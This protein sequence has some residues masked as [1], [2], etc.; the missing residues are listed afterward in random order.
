MLLAVTAVGA[1]PVPIPAN[2]GGVAGYVAETPALP[3]DRLLR[4]DGS[5][6]LQSGYRGT[7]SIDGWRMAPGPD[8]APRFEKAITEDISRLPDAIDP[9]AAVESSDA[10]WDDR[11]ILQGMNNRVLALAMD[12]SGNLYAGG[13][14]TTA[15]GISASYIAK[16]NGRVWSALGSGMNFWVS[17]LAM[18]GSGNLYAGGGFTTAGGISASYIAKWN[19]TVWSALG[20]GMNAWVYAL[21]MDG[22][23]NLYAGGGFTT[24]GGISANYIAKW[25]GTVWSALGSGM[26]GNVSALAMD[27]SGNLYAGG[28]FTTAGGISANYIAKWNGTVWSALGSGMNG[29]VSALAMDGSGNLYAGGYFTTA[30]GISASYIAKWNGTVWSAL[31]SG[32]NNLGYV[33][34]LAMDGS[35]NLYAG[36]GFTT[37][38]GI[39]ARYIAKWNGTV[40]SALGPGMNTWVQALVT[41]GSG[42]LYA[43]GLFQAAGGISASYIAK[44]NRTVWSA[45]GSGMNNRVL[46]LAMDGSGNLYAGGGF[47]TAGGISASYIAKW[48]G[49]VWSALGSGMNAWVY[50]LAMDGSGNL[51][52][53]G[54]FT[55]AGGISASYIAKWNGTVWSAL[56][57]GMND[58]VGALAMDGSGNLYAGGGFS[59]AGGISAHCVAKWNGTVWSALGLGMW[60]PVGALAMDGSGNLYAGGGFTTAGGISARCIAKWNGTVWSA[61]GSGMNNSVSSLAMDGSNLYAGGDFTTAGGIS[62]SYIAK[63]NG[64]VWS[65]LGSGMNN[66]VGALAMD[67]G[68]NLYAGGNFTTAGGIL[69]SYVAKWNGTVWSALGSGMNDSVSSLA[70]DGSGNLYTGGYFTTAGAKASVH[71]AIWHAEIPPEAPLT[72]TSPANA[73][74]VSTNNVPFS[75]SN[76]VADYY[77]IWVD[78]E[79]SFSSPELQPAFLAPNGLDSLRTNSFDLSGSSLGAG[80]TY[81]WKVKAYSGTSSVE[82]AVWS[83]TYEPPVLT[84]PTWAPL[85]R[86]YK[87]ADTDHFYTTNEG[88]LN[89]AE[90]SLFR[91]ERVEGFVSTQRFGHADM[92]EL[93]RF[94]DEGRR[95]H[96]YTLEHAPPASSS[97]VDS[98][99]AAGHLYEG[100][101]GFVYRTP[102]PGLVPLYHVSKVDLSDHLYTISEVEVAQIPV[103]WPGQFAPEV[104]IGWVSPTGDT[105]WIPGNVWAGMVGDGISLGTGNF[106]HYTKTSFSIPTVGLPLEFEHVYNSRAVH[107]ASQTMPLGPGWSNNY[108]VYVTTVPD[109]YLVSWP[110][111]SLHRYSQATGKCLEDTFGVYD[112]M[113]VFGGGHFEIKK[114]NQIVYAFHKPDGTTTG[115]PSVLTSIRDRNQ[116]TITLAY[117]PSGLRRLS[118]VTD[119]AG[120]QL[121]F[122]YRADWGFEN[123]IREVRDVAGNRTASFAYED[124]NGNLTSFTDCA[125]QVTRYFYDEGDTLQGQNH[126]LTQIRLP[127]G[128]VIDNAYEGR[129]VKTQSGGVGS[130]SINYGVQQAT[131]QM[132]ATEQ[133]TTTYD[134]TPEGLIRRLQVSG[135]AGADSLRRDDPDNPA[136]PTWVQD[137]KGQVTT[138]AY[139]VRGNATVV[140]NPYGTDAYTY[141]A[142]NNVLSHEDANHH[143]ATLAY[144]GNG[145]LTSVTDHM[146]HATTLSRRTN[147][148]V[149]WAEN[150]LG[151]RTT[152]DYDQYGNPIFV[153]DNLNNGTTFTYDAVGHML[154]QTDAEG[155]TTTFTHD[156]GDRMASAHS[157][158]NG[159]TSY[160]YDLNGLLETVTDPLE[161]QTRWTYNNL[162]LVASITNANL[163]Q[164]SYQYNANGS[165]ASRERPT[166]TTSY[167]YDQAGRLTGISSSGATLERDDNGNITRL[168]DTNGIMT[169]S[170]D[171]NNRLTSQ[172][173]FYLQTVGYE[174]DPVGNL[175]RL[176]YPG[177]KPVTYAYDPVNRLTSVTDWNGRSTS[178]GY[179]DDG[180]LEDISYAN[181]THAHFVYDE[182][183][184]LIGLTHTSATD[185]VIASYAYTLDRLGN[186]VGEDRTEPLAAPVLENRSVTSTYDAANRILTAGA[187]AYAFDGAGNM[188][189]RTGP[190]AITCTFDPENRLT[191]ISGATT[192]SFTYDTFGNRWAATRNGTTTRYVLDL[193]GPMSQVLMETDVSGNPTAYYVYGRGLISRIGTGS[194]P[195]YGY[196]HFNRVGSIVAVSALDGATLTHK[197]TYSPFGETLGVAEDGANPFQ[198]GGWYG[199]MAEGSNQYYARARFYDA[200]LGR[201]WSEDPVWAE[202]AYVYSGSNPVLYIDPDGR[203]AW[204]DNWKESSKKAMKNTWSDIESGRALA[205]GSKV[206]SAV[207]SLGFTLLVDRVYMKQVDDLVCSV[208]LSSRSTQRW[209]GI[210]YGAGYA[211][212]LAPSVMGVGL[213]RLLGLGG[214]VSDAVKSAGMVKTIVP[215]QS[216]IE[217]AV[218][219]CGQRGGAR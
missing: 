23:G 20:S 101:A 118:T 202:N 160:G 201:F 95:C 76:V 147:G 27:G 213:P 171:A 30:G 66:P 115:Y 200:P 81:Y 3:L 113:T 83:F 188:V 22:S 126:Q 11:F 173:D 207:S 140:Q 127:R 144:D 24:A 57:S 58:L 50:A 84:V 170:Y 204:W 109:L 139:D 216:D 177:G 90:N 132:T 134:F 19:G 172:T 60:N 137:S 32:M 85:Y 12:G 190:D 59:T 120:R 49:T 70:M 129:R 88:Q 219:R 146:G 150:P 196:Y 61:L 142:M 18:D 121:T 217:T 145:N 111:G 52:A 39:S 77:Q 125:G 182:A 38:G 124:S 9:G 103:V 205:A 36:G 69:A 155:H 105:P 133:I 14:F 116:N 141:D 148:L 162:D 186:I 28:Y 94:Y 165:L 156:C 16:W 175:T 86:L 62:A 215:I 185:S 75:W 13:G 63:W 78:D 212:K 174:Y 164:T 166:G 21:A 187:A 189:S 128:N 195:E 2:D 46:A 117:E 67:G 73:S 199:V 181:G 40:W 143:T 107:L 119:P 102:Q 159:T 43:G 33:S 91:R 82:S 151:H 71:F 41:D 29:N 169:F 51:Y 112:Q 194:T 64:T 192:A 179:R 161:H 218:K 180:S 6:D 176:I 89:I 97:V 31:G 106:Q 5:L 138:Y 74:V 55:T 92:A 163:N 93:F 26:N 42:N 47:T 7:V 209:I 99:I 203:A 183:D 45:L 131:V 154:S 110:D 122:A 100:I 8:G 135:I 214:T 4:A 25:N 211:L 130:L 198:F 114:K 1:D 68:G 34:V 206:F 149:D 184:R 152:F 208:D 136:L 193:H 48:N 79:S 54:G 87:A 35:G 17:A 197:Y 167:I 104:V 98:L 44:W 37:A 123:L 191:S 168:Q 65:A 10:Q 72:L 53:G 158:E 178:Y 96:I 210:A 157:P 56:G 153:R 80:R 108:C 15:G